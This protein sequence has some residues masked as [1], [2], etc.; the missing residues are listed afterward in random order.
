MTRFQRE[1]TRSCTLPSHFAPFETSTVSPPH[2]STAV[3]PIQ[4]PHR[5]CS[6]RKLSRPGRSPTPSSALAQNRPLHR[7]RYRLPRGGMLDWSMRRCLRTSSS[8]FACTIVHDHFRARHGQHIR[9][10]CQLLTGFVWCDHALRTVSPSRC[11]HDDP[12]IHDIFVDPRS[13]T[14]TLYYHDTI[15]RLLIR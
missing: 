10:S 4:H 1:H 8:P 11:L 6:L 12:T 14:R 5:N 13:A 15:D 7:Q 2:P 9:P 3:A